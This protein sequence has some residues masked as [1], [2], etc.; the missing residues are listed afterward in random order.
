MLYFCLKFN[1]IKTNLSQT[2]YIS[3]IFIQVDILSAKIETTGIQSESLKTEEIGILKENLCKLTHYGNRLRESLEAQ[4]NMQKAFYRDQ[5]QQTHLSGKLRS[6]TTGVKNL[7]RAESL[8][9]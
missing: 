9:T 1:N 4:N 2:C 7:F 3:F 6:L 5:N 8:Q